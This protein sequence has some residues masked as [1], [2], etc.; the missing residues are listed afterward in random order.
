MIKKFFSIKDFAVFKNFKWDDNVTDKDG[1]EVNLAKVN[2]IYGHNYSGKTSLSRIV[3]ALEKNTISDKYASPE[4]EVLFD[5][6]NVYN[7]DNF[8]SCK[9]PIRVFNED[10]VTE[11]LG[12]LTNPDSSILP[13]TI[14]GEKNKETSLEIDRVSSELGTNEIGK[15]TQLYKELKVLDKSVHEQKHEYD[16]AVNRFSAQLV[17]KAK[18]IKDAAITYNVPTYNK[19]KLEADIDKVNNNDYVP[20]SEDKKTELNRNLYDQVKSNV[21]LLPSLSLNFQEICSDAGELL[22]REIGSSNKIVGLLRDAALNDWVREGCRLHENKSNVCAFCGNIISDQRWAV[23]HAHFDE[24][25]QNLNKDIDDLILKIKSEK[26]YINTFLNIDVNLF[27]SKYQNILEN[28]LK[29]GY[30]NVV[31][32]YIEQLD[33]IIKMLITRKDNIIKPI[34]IKMSVD[35]SKYLFNIVENYNLICK[36]ANKYT[37]NMIAEQ[38]TARERLRLDEVYLFCSMIDFNNTSKKLSEMKNA[39]DNINTKLEKLKLDILEREKYIKDKKLE[40]QDESDGAR[41]INIYLNNYFGHHHLALKPQK[42]ANG[43]SAKIYFEIQRDG[44]KAYNLSEGER[45]L[46]AF[47]Y[48]IAKLDDVLTKS[49]KPIIWI[50]DPISSLDSNHIFFVY[51]MLKTHILDNRNFEQLF[52]ATHN[53][54][55]LKYLNSFNA[56]K[57]EHQY[58]LIERNGKYSLIKKLPKYL[59]VHGTEF[60]YWFKI[61]YHVSL[62]ENIDDDNRWLFEIF[63]NA[64]RKFFETL[65]YYKYPNKLP[66]SEKLLHLFGKSKVSAILIDKIFDEYSHASGDLENESSPIIEVPEMIFAAREIIKKIKE[67]ES[68][69][70]ALMDTIDE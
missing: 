14:L 23:L 13:I 2:I 47:C 6:G 56:N 55:F 48:F 26:E 65:L 59:R 66:V 30:K 31:L 3:R 7:Q 45:K 68:Q 63:A 21:P 20:L 37:V 44:K 35:Y 19:P 24:E 15:E 53:L 43:V 69:Y 9:A 16:E 27:Y 50:D 1:Q 67:D 39:Y 61:I 64:T 5:D 46:V 11:N 38:A 42:D 60:N 4:F 62:A 12:F 40:L 70:N 33:I 22:S 58:L 8:T 18:S 29:K 10:F 52:V 49:L 36:D 17:Q 54:T 28:G 34:L 51:S 41:L 25:S 57:Y 32:K